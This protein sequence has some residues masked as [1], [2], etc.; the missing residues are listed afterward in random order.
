VFDPGNYDYIVQYVFSD[1]G[2]ITFSMG[3]TGF[4]NPSR[5]F[6]AHMHNALWR[7]HP[8]LGGG[9]VSN[10]FL[11]T[12]KEKLPPLP[13]GLSL[14]TDSSQPA[15]IEGS[16]DFD[17]QAFTTL[18]VEGP[19]QDSFHHRMGYVLEPLLDGISR[20]DDTAPIWPNVTEGFAQHDFFITKFNPTELLDS[21][22]DPASGAYRDP[23]GYLFAAP[24]HEPVVNADVVLW[25]R[26]STHHMPRDEDRPNWPGH[27]TP[28][29]GITLV[30]WM[31][32]ELVPH[33][34][35]DF[36]PLGGP[37]YCGSCGNG[38]CDNNEDCCT[39]AEDCA[40]A[41]SPSCC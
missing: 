28:D 5:P 37:H 3:A 16:F 34:F 19:S 13:P 21:I 11:D 8:N 27:T 14:A 39:C 29:R 9:A 2:T 38:V 17:A 30:H 26:S 10:V 12:H 35:F 31:G 36:N 15:L 25:Y 40:P 6:E 18:R 41:G 1:D 24:A 20:H 33:D 4:N 23:D 22:G 32:F 7:I